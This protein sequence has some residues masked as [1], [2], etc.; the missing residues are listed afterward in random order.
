[1]NRSV[2]LGMSILYISKIIIMYDYLYDYVNPNYGREAEIYYTDTGSFI[3][4]IKSENNLAENS[5]RIIRLPTL[6][7]KV[8]DHYA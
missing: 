8:A 7:L 2:H 5:L 3:V 4:H 1:M 6:T